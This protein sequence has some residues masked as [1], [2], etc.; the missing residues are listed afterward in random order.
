MIATAIIA[1]I[2]F[3]ALTLSVVIHPAVNIGRLRI[4]LYWVIAL[5]GALVLLC[6][7]LAPLD[8]V[9]NAFI[10]DS[11]V[12]PLKI[13]ALFLSMTFLSVYLDEVGFFARYVK[14]PTSSR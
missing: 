1:S 5:V 2:T 12:N 11:A 7:Q 8:A 13:L 10:T 14:K 9:W 4:G 3:I 6:A